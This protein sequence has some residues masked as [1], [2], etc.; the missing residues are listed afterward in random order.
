MEREIFSNTMQHS[1]VIWGLEAGALA[2]KALFTALFTRARDVQ[3]GLPGRCELRGSRLKYVKHIFCV[4]VRIV[5]NG[6]L[7][8]RELAV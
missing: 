7:A 2:L 8:Q 3:T 1:H 4:R 5:H 6:S